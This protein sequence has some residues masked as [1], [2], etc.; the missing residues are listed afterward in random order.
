M[1]FAIYHILYHSSKFQIPVI[2][3]GNIFLADSIFFAIPVQCPR[4]AMW[5]RNLRISHINR[6]RPADII[7]IIQISCQLHFAHLTKRLT[8]PSHH[9]LTARSKCRLRSR[10]SN[11]NPTESK[12]FRPLNRLRIRGIRGIWVIR[13]PLIFISQTP[14]T[15]RNLMRHNC[16][17]LVIF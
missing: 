3:F 16:S 14:D 5:N 6:R 9:A 13:I 7:R 12:H 17:I 2:G 10:L 15:V 11:S 1:L 4:F 8:K